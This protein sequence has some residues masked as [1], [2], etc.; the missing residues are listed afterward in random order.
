MYYTFFIN[1]TFSAWHA[2]EGNVDHKFGNE[3]TNLIN[4]KSFQEINNNR[5]SSIP[6]KQDL[7]RSIKPHRN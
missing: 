4:P 6:Q 1:I 2:R 3:F 5:L 7:Y